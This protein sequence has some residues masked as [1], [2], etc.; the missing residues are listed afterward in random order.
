MVCTMLVSTVLVS[1]LAGCRTGEATPDR[2]ALIDSRDW[3]DPR[4]LDPAKATDVPS[5]RA[6]AYLFD[7]LTKFTPAG[8]VQPSIARSWDVSPD[9]LQY[10]FHLRAD[11]RFHDGA[12]LLARHVAQSF[13]RVLDPATKGGTVWPLYPIKGARAFAD[14]KSDGKGTALGIETPNDTTVIITLDEPFAIFPKLLA[15]PVA[16]ILPDS[17]GVDFSEHPIGTG[18][19]KLVE[20]KHDD[21][22]KFARNATYFGGAPS[23]DTLIARIIP[24]PSTAVAEFEA[25][26]VDILYVPEDQTRDWEETDTKKATLVSAPALR[27]WYMGVNVTR[28]PLKDVRVRQAI[29]HAIDVPT[30][31]AQ[32]LAGRGTIAAGVIPPTLEGF[33]KARQPYAYDTL[34]ARKLLADAGYANGIDLELW[35]SQTAPMPRLAQAIQ[36][37]LATVGVRIKLVQRD[38][39]SMRAAA[40]AGQ[41]D[42]VVK[43]WYADYPDAENFLYPLLHTANRGAGGNVSFFSD[44]TFD[45]LVDASRRESDA[46]KRA[47]L[48]AAAD[49]V[50]YA[51]VGMVPLFFYNE[52]YAV[53]P[54]VKGFEVPVIFNGQRWERVRMRTEKGR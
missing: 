11:V 45:R 34:A 15:M 54:W 4:S 18:P 35:S 27:L 22:L 21:Y 9:G 28:G 37:Y 25:G 38:A 46:A 13:R 30:L 39:S 44:A 33:D 42:L 32:L 43:D 7:G 40:R 48:Y 36:A 1:T 47:V 17:V 51:Q 12:P 19:W 29:A 20:W 24:E 5:G 31:L 6:V 16:S 53:Q 2:H 14:G 8:Q 3:Y 49:S 52:V 26:T 10:T 23:I 50:G 41:T